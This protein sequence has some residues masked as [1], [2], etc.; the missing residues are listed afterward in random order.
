MVE[1]T[2]RRVKGVK[3][4]SGFECDPN[5][6]NPQGCQTVS[7]ANFD[8]YQ[9]CFRRVVASIDTHYRKLWDVAVSDYA[10]YQHFLE[11]KRY[12]NAAILLNGS[13]RSNNTRTLITAWRSQLSSR[14]AHWLL[15]ADP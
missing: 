15:L 11:A 9:K 8:C 1:V 13:F 5:D 12:T 7:S 10:A 3:P 6:F 14:V 2:V 4:K